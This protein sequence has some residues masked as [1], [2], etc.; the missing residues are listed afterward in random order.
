MAIKLH[1][2]TAIE[3]IPMTP[4]IDVVFLLLI[5]FLVATTLSQ[6][7][8]QIDILLPSA[9]EAQPLIVRPQE[10][11]VNIHAE[12]RYSVRGEHEVGL[13]RLQQVLNQEAAEAASRHRRASVIFRA[14]KRCQLDYV[15]AA[16]N[17]CKRARIKDYTV[18]TIGEGG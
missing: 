7:E 16:I 2:K 13:A 10:I 11:I 9:S 18:S 5:F 3:S 12:G 17:A 1:E 8:R 15:V 4:L 14:D 6:E